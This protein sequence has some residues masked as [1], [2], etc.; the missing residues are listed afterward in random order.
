SYHFQVNLGGILDVLSNHLYKRP[1]VFLREL[2]Q[3]GVDAITLRQKKEPAW[4][5]G[6]ITISVT[7]G[8]KLVFH[9]NGA[10]LDEGE[11]HRFLA[12]IGQSSK[13]ALVNGTLP[14]DYIGRFGI[15]LL[16]CFLVSDSIV[17]HTRPAAGGPAHVWTGHADGTYTLEPLEDCPPGTSVILTAKLGAESYFQRQTVADLV[18]Y[19]GLA[20]PVPVYLEGE[21]ERINQ[22]PD[23]FSAISRSQLLAFGQWLF[24][25]E[26]LDAIPIQ[27]SHISGVAYILPYRT[28]V[29]AKNCHRIYLKQMLLTEQGDTLLP[30]WAFFLQCFLNT[31]G[32]RPTASREDFY[33]DSALEEAREEFS[34]AVGRYLADLARDDPERLRR[35]VEVHVEAIKSM[36]VWDEVLFRLFIDYLP[37]ETSEGVMTGVALKKAGEGAWVSSVPK[38]KQ[39][40]PIFLAQ[41]KLLLCTGYT[42]DEELIAKLAHTYRLPLAP[43]VEDQ[44]DVVLELP[45]PEEEH[46]AFALLQAADRS[47]RPFDCQADLR[48]FLPHDLPALYTV[49]GEVQFLRQIQSAKEEKSIFSGALTSL[50]ES[51]ETRPLATLYLNQNSPLIRRLTRLTESALLESAVQVL[52]MQAMLA[53]GY[54]LRGG[55]LKVLNQALLTLLDHASGEENM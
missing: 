51:V 31:R 14:E 17:V 33:E 25:E 4:H 37:F 7:P 50:L 41:G 27:T 24:E 36:A 35:L 13:T 2:L 22:I 9:D 55:E 45:T 5:R 16:A 47:L 43:L 11:I 42:S 52:Y 21:D 53:G 19:Y 20:L 38:F 40:K 48:C 1:D 3:N 15:G 28:S 6:R 49:S 30:A 44:M 34:G 12:V 23:N 10:G 29:S 18:R 8:R 54:P 32:L 39:L 46:R 26:F